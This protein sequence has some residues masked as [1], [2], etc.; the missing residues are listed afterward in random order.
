MREACEAVWARL[1]DRTVDELVELPLMSDPASRAAL[2]VLFRAILCSTLM[3]RNLA[4]I[5]VCAAIELSL[6]RGNAD[7]SCFAYAYLGWMTG[8][9]YGRPDG[10]RFGRVAMGLMERKGLKRLQAIVQL[11]CATQI[12][13]WSAPI[14]EAR[15]LIRSSFALALASGDRLSAVSAH[16][17]LVTHQLVAGEPLDSAAHEAAVGLGIAREAQAGDFVVL[18]AALGGLARSLQGQA[19]RPGSLDSDD[20]D[21]AAVERHYAEAPHL[22]ALECWYLVRKLQARFFA[23]EFAAALEAGQRAQALLWSTPALLEVAEC[24]F[25]TALAHAGACADKPNEAKAGHAQAATRSLERLEAWARDCPSTFENRALLVAAELARVEQREPEAM[26]LYDRAIASA[27]THGLVHNEAL[28]NELAGAFYEARG[29]DRIARAYLEDA[30]AGYRRWGAHGKVRELEGRRALAGVEDAAISLAGTV[31]TPVARLDLGTVTQVLQAVSG[32]IDLQA[33]ATTIMRAALAHA[34]AERALLIVPQP[35]GPPRIEA[36]ARTDGDAVRIEV[37]PADITPESLPGAALQ[38]VLRT[39]EH[40]LLADAKADPAWAGDDYVRLRRTRSMLCLPLL[41]QARLVGVL[42]LENQLAAGIFTPARMD[43]LRLLASEAAI[44]LENAQ[45]YRDVQEREARM[46]RLVDANIVGIVLWHRDG[47]ILEANDA[48]L[49]LVG[50]S[51]DEVASGRMPWPDLTRSD[52]AAADARAFAMPSEHDTLQAVECQLLRGDGGHVPVLVGVAR[53]DA[54]PDEGV[55]FFLDLTERKQAENA[56]HELQARLADANRIASVGHLAAAIAHELNQ[57]LAGIM[58][59]ASTGMRMLAAEPADVTGAGETARRT[60]RDAQRASEVIRRL[61]DLFARKAPELESIEL[62]DLVREVLALYELDLRRGDVQVVLELATNLPSA[63]VDRV[64][65]QQVI[66]NLLRNAADA[67]RGVEDRPRRLTLRTTLVEGDLVRLDVEDSG[68][69]IAP[70][71]RE[72]LFDPFFTTKADGM[73]IGLSV[74]RSIMERHGGRLWVT[75]GQGPGA[76]FA[77]TLPATTG[78][79]PD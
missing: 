57:P 62:N 56:Y 70:E 8:W 46:R 43:L 17:L 34:G 72:Q 21:E 66:L 40:V 51:R 7:G 67:M 3:D 26:R 32:E 33:L 29:F 59:N 63:R 2:E 14:A 71:V 5:L 50:Q 28:A 75:E 24:E 76:C 73:G 77:L 68:V 55:G 47:R 58:N 12:V 74:S 31:F 9:Q 27:R 44:A 22:P 78:G 39:R 79:G 53:F 37:E 49:R 25:F 23:G 4:G 18:A 41:K 10:Y 65:L 64:Q 15:E 16:C 45:L 30:R 35:D 38:Y 19:R 20:L 36:E 11:T 42:Y 13:S 1:T 6:D 52:G 61:R 54:T 48:F 60:I 69:G